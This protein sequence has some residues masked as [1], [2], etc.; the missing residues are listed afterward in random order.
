MLKHALDIDL[1]PA[2]YSVPSLKK[3]KQNKKAPRFLSNEEIPLLLKAAK[4]FSDQMQCYAM[5]MLFA[6][7]RSG[8]ALNL[9]PC[10]VDIDQ[11][12]ILVTPYKFKDKETGEE[13]SWSP[14]SYQKRAITLLD[15]LR[16]YL[17]IRKQEVNGSRYIVVGS[18]KPQ[19]A[20]MIKRSFIDIVKV[21]G[22]PHVGEEKV[23]AHVLRHTFA[24]HCVMNGISL[25]DVSKLLGHSSITTTEVYAHLAKDHLHDSVK[26]LS[27]GDLNQ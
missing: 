16:S 20:Y 7:L 5:V 13:V 9:R 4:D 25:F 12:R 21:A 23:T 24:S 14:K 2:S 6:G 1:M 22:L 27:F 10:D 8:E 3:L 19:S 11:G 17:A 18:G 15:N 26:K